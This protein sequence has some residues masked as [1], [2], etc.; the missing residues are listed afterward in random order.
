M[1]NNLH[2][3]DV[4]WVA[5]VELRR[6]GG[7]FYRA[8]STFSAS[9]GWVSYSRSDRNKSMQI[10]ARITFDPGK[11]GAVEFRTAKFIRSYEG[12]SNNSGALSRR[13]DRNGAER[14][15]ARLDKPLLP[16]CA[17]ILLSAPGALLRRETPPTLWN[18]RQ[19]ESD[20]YP[21][22]PVYYL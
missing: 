15:G 4:S 1:K 22:S 5:I 9:L 7:F 13:A 14:R 21:T 20:F 19:R 2:W 6:R 10:R 17:A 12:H 11:I 8:R 16:V 3:F 18:G